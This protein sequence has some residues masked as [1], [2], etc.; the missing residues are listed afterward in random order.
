VGEAASGGGLVRLYS[1]INNQPR[2]DTNNVINVRLDRLARTVN[3]CND[4]VCVQQ[5]NL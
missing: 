5:A 1:R 2:D 3:H 4:K